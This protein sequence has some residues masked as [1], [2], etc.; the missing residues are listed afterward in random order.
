MRNYSLTCMCSC[1]S[2]SLLIVFNA[3]IELDD[4]YDPLGPK[5]DSYIPPDI[6]MIDFAHSYLHVSENAD[7]AS[8]TRSSSG[9]PDTNI[10]DSLKSLCDLLEGNQ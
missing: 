7:A 4:Q 9:G 3:G 10:L 1:Y 8:A 5:D 2:A 6:R